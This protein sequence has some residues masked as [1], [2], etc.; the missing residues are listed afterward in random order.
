[1]LAGT[2]YTLCNNYAYSY[3]VLQRRPPSQLGF[4]YCIYN[5]MWCMVVQCDVDAR[6]QPIG[7]SVAMNAA[8]PDQSAGFERERH[9]C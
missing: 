3:I 1:M 4:I 2:T 6:P 8:T 5:Y 9:Q 7:E